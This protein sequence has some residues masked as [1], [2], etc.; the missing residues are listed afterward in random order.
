MQQV[1][2]L[3]NHF[4][5]MCSLDKVWHVKPQRPCTGMPLFLA[6]CCGVV[7]LLTSPCACC[8]QAYHFDVTM[9]PMRRPRP[10]EDEAMTSAS[11]LQDRP[12]PVEMTRCLPPGIA[13]QCTQTI[14]FTCMLVTAMSSLNHIA[15]CTF[16]GPQQHPAQAYCLTTRICMQ[17]RHDASGH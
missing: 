16:H 13:H 6:M 8:R 11:S 7:K 1:G 3:A 12:P 2:I 9:H 14:L 10:G 5:V 15:L 17:A 4:R